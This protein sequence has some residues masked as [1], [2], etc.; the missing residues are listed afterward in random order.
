[1]KAIEFL[2]YCGF[3][4]VNECVMLT[5]HFHKDWAEGITRQANAD[6]HPAA[7]VGQ[8]SSLSPDLTISCFVCVPAAVMSFVTLVDTL[9][10]T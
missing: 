4:E 2:P 7:V 3:V 6:G 9:S 1:M 5:E 10:T 8:A